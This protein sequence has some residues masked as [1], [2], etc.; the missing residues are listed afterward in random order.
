MDK[1]SDYIKVID[2]LSE[3]ECDY[4]LNCINKQKYIEEFY[5]ATV[6]DEKG[7][8]AVVYHSSRNNLQTFIKPGSELDSL[9]YSKVSEGYQ[10]WWSSINFELSQSSFFRNLNDTGYQI[11]K[12]EIG[13]YYNYHV[14]N[15]VTNNNQNR[16]LSIVIYINDDYEGGELQFP[17]YTYKPSKGQGIFF[18]SDWLYPHKSCPILKGVKYSIVTWLYE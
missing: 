8:N 15:S 11:N 3:S 2:L 4:I 1:L 14:D 5:D 7:S 10:K 12:Y 16:V 13:Q 18:P 17:F 6:Y 9:I